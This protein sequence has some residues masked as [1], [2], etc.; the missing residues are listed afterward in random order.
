MLGKIMFSLPENVEGTQAA[1]FAP[2]FRSISSYFVRRQSAGGFLSPI[3]QTTYQQLWDQQVSISYLFGLD[4]TVPQQWQHIRERETSLKELKKAADEGTLGTF[5]GRTAEL[6]TLLTLAENR[7]RE[8][9]EHVSNFQI[10]PEYRNLEQEADQLTRELGTLMDENTIDRLLLS[11]LQKALNHEADPTIADLE[12]LYE[13]AGV[14]LSNS[15]VRRFEDV[16]RFH[17]SIIANRR[18]YLG[19]EVTGARQRIMAREDRMP[20]ISDRRAK[21]MA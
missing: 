14:I 8:L 16:R 20:K 15:I 6:R 5:I 7:S 4:W 21:I 18:S 2:T 1:R 11:E 12:R 9:R 10:L 3:K 17:E 19:S 13:E